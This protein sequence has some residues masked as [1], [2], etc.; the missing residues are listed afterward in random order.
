MLN[1]LNFNS[2]TDEGIGRTQTAGG[3]DSPPAN[4]EKRNDL[5]L[6][7]GRW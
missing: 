5:Q 7:N 1:E 6:A 2:H 4:S 3:I